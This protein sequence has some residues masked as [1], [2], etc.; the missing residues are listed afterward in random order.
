AAPSPSTRNLQDRGPAQAAMGDQHLLAE[1]VMIRL[2]DHFRRH[3]RHVAVP[4]AISKG[5]YERHKRGLVATIFNPNWPPIDIR[6]ASRPFWGWKVPP[7]QPR[8]RARENRRIQ[9]APRTPWCA[10]LPGF[11]SVEKYAL[12][13]PRTRASNLYI[14]NSLT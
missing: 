11:G 9:C 6:T 12:P 14:R 3:A 10:A 8:G 4:A 1:G 5:Q 2:C 7:W 13:P